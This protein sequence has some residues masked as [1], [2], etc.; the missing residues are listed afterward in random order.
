VVGREDGCF[1][2]HHFE[3][4]NEEEFSIAKEPREIEQSIGCLN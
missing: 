2:S 3:L 1:G 4:G